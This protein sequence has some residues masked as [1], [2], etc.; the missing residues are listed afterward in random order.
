VFFTRQKKVVVLLAT[1]IALTTFSHAE[2]KPLTLKGLVKPFTTSSNTHTVKRKDTRPVISSVTITGNRSVSKNEIKLL[3]TTKVGDRLNPYKLNRN[4]KNIKSLGAFKSVHSDVEKKD[5]QAAI[6]FIV[7]EF[8]IVHNINLDGASIVSKNILLEKMLSKK[9]KAYNLTHTRKDIQAIEDYYHDNGYFKAKVY[10]VTNPEKSSDNLTFYIAE[11]EIDEI[12][13]TGNLKTQDYVIIRELD[14]KPGDI[15]SEKQLK[16]NIRR[17]YNLNYFTQINPKFS[18]GT[19]PHTYKLEIEIVEKETNGSFTLGGGYSPNSGFSLFSDLYWDNIF[20]SGQLIMLKGNFAFGNSSLSNRNSTYQFKYHN[21]WMW[22]ERRSFTFRTW[23]T[24]GNISTINPLGGNL[25]SQDETRRGFDVAVGIPH[26]YDFRTSHALK[27][28]SVVLN[29]LLRDFSIY[30]YKFGVSYD[31]RD[32]R[33][34]PREGLFHSLT[35]EQGLKFRHNALSFTQFELALK[36]FIPTFK[37]QTIALRTDLGYLM[38]PQISDTDL[39]NSEWYYIGGGST[40]R[41]Y[42]DLFPFAFGNKRM[43]T[44]VEYRFL[45]TQVFQTVLFVDAGSASL[46]SDVFHPGGWKMGK[47]I[48]IRFNVAPVGP[49]RLDWGFDEEGVGR[50]HFSMGHSF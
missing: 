24:D 6:T 50:V 12:L 36:R 14:I 35:V 32:F 30:S 1:L 26:T 22:D 4:V 21:P 31:T 34:N 39:F 33:A 27:Y 37:K 44:S 3:I 49:I 2:V 40:V 18:P 42:D 17:I 15:I 19:N 46:N 41:G 11:G 20:G 38:S 43:I 28:E 10:K 29:D 7:E 45:F 23:L 13:I 8:P 5:N 48:G 47:G 25:T 16:Q 9:E